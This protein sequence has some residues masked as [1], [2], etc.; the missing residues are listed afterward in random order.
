MAKTLKA[1]RL[2]EEAIEILKKL[3]EKHKRSE[4]NMIEVLLLDAAK[5]LK[6][7]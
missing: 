3:C 2:S 6:K 7:K 4:A 5:D 1:F